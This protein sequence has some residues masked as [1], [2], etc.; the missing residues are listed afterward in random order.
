MLL[1]F[2]MGVVCSFVRDCN[3]GWYRAVVDRTRGVRLSMKYSTYGICL[4]LDSSVNTN[5][6]DD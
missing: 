5:S 3:G 4:M 6:N 2:L 1:E